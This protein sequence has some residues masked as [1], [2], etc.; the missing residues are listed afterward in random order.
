MRMNI[1]V[2]KV[3]F[4]FLIFRPRGRKRFKAVTKISYRER[5]LISA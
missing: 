2:L 4:A 3:C 5:I 1:F